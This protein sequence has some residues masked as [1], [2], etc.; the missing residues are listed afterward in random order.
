MF[1]KHLLFIFI[2]LTEA[3]CLIKGYI[4]YSKSLI[5][6]WKVS[7]NKFNN[8]T[9]IQTNYIID[10]GAWSVIQILYTGKSFPFKFRQ[11]CRCCLIGCRRT[12]LFFHQ[13]F[14]SDTHQSPLRRESFTGW[15]GCNITH[16][17]TKNNISL[18]AHRQIP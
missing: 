17:H 8:Q 14:C 18:N 12:I 5:M 2:C 3:V 16:T 7:L 1:Y 13:Q 6:Q 4:Y 9:A 11:L 10:F 15:I